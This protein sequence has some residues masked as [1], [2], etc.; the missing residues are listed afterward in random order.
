MLDIQ[1]V[2]DGEVRLSGRFDA[3][4]VSQ[5]SAVFSELQTSADVDFERLEYISSAGLG[6]LLETQHRLSADGHALRLV[7]MNPHV[8]LILECAGFDL[9]FAID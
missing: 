2:A 8:R 6:V 7:K 9:I 1:L 3:N 4:G 5:A